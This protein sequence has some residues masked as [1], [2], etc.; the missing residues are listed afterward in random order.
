MNLSTRESGLVFDIMQDLSFG[1]DAAELRL[2]TG[3]KLLDLLQ[4]DYFAS[5]IWSPS[6]NQFRDRVSINM[7]DDNLVA[8]ESHYQYCDPITPSLQRRR[9]ATCVSEVMPRRQFIRT[10]FFNDFLARDGL[11]FGVNYYAYA[12]SV[13]IGDMRIWRRSGKSDFTT[14][15]LAVLDAIGPSF[16]N[17]MRNALRREHSAS[18]A[19][20]LSPEFNQAIHNANLTRREQDICAAMS[21]GLA[22]KAIASSLG[23]SVT[24]VRTHVRH[25]YEKFA[26]NSRSQLLSC[27]VCPG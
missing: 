23:I 5:Y 13:N 22:D 9:K 19:I 2:L 7:S 25:I 20:H 11:H 17:A 10:E 14:R 21:Q 16:T 15:D 26:V 4:A 24:T 27:L 6:G 3:R 8:Y 18:P 1:H 12:G